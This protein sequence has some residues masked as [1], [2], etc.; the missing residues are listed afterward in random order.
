MGF[1]GVGEMMLVTIGPDMWGHVCHI[2][3]VFILSF[4]D[5]RAINFLSIRVKYAFGL[6]ELGNV[7]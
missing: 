4:R 3:G 6:H 5:M 1:M 2:R 7:T